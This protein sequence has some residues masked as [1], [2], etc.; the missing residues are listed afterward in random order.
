[1]KVMQLCLSTGVGGL[2]LYVSRTAKQLRNKQIDCVA[3]VQG[4]TMLA[5][6]LRDEKIRCFYIRRTKGLS[7]FTA[8]RLA[9]LIDS[10]AVDVLHMHWGKDLPL[11]ALAKKLAERPVKLVY[12]RQ[13]MITR[14]KHD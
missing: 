6:R 5:Q 7:Y 13:M 9:E 3:A 14:P 1:M 8:K 11:A 10:E 4:D 2:E 12:T